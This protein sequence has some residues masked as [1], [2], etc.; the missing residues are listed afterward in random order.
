M[1]SNMLHEFKYAAN[2][3]FEN[4]FEDFIGIQNN[5]E[6]LLRKVP[7]TDVIQCS[8][9]S[10]SDP[11]HQLRIFI[12]LLAINLHTAPCI[13]T[14]NLNT[15]SHRTRRHFAA[16]APFSPADACS[17]T[18]TC[19]NM[20]T[21]NVWQFCSLR[22]CCLSILC[23]MTRGHILT[24]ARI[25]RWQCYSPPPA[26]PPSLRFI[27]L[28]ILRRIAFFMLALCIRDWFAIR[29][30]ERAAVRP[31]EPNCV[32]VCAF[33]V[34]AFA[35]HKIAVRSLRS[36]HTFST[37]GREHVTNCCGWETM[38]RERMACA[39]RVRGFCSW[40]QTACMLAVVFQSYSMGFAAKRK[41]ITKSRVKCRNTNC[42]FVY[43]IENCILFA[44]KFQQFCIY[45]CTVCLYI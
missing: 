33:E 11:S 18:T 22:C 2:R 1:N 26:P 19:C 13:C 41:A 27:R 40:P 8:S 30:S 42:L 35:A 20:C 4:L 31:M 29:N 36:P 14:T 45:K 10:D 21:P 12:H 24:L 44:S 3:S 5:P 23:K 7:S 39:Y 37:I 32:C 9:K 6:C 38:A 15:Q 16:L 43:N 28:K 34:I 17:G 25:I